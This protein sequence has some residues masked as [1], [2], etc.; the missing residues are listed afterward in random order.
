M[1]A[2]RT[3]NLFARKT[4][5][6]LDVP[7]AV[8]AG[9]LEFAYT[10]FVHVLDDGERPQPHPHRRVIKQSEMRDKKGSKIFGN[11]FEPF[12]CPIPLYLV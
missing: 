11:V 4:F 12:C 1:V 2:S 5:V 9:E 10:L 6:A 3:L 7:V 8:R